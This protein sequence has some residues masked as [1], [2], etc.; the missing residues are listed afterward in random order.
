[1]KYDF[2]TL[3]MRDKI[4]SSKWA[5]MKRQNPNVKEGIVPFSTADMEFVCPPEFT[6]GLKDYI[7]GM[8]FGY[9]IAGASYFEAVIDWMRRRH[10]WKIEREWIVMTPGVVTALYHSVRA[11]TDPGDG[12]LLMT[13]AYYP[14]YSAIENSG[15]TLVDVPLLIENDQYAIDFDLLEQE[16]KKPE[17][18]LI[19]FCS[20]AN[21]GGRVWSREELIRFG[22]ICIDN[23]LVIVSDD[24]HFDLIL[25]GYEHTV[26]ANI[27]DEFKEHSV[28]CT[29]P[30]KTF[31]LAGMSSSNII[32]ANE[33]LRKK[34][35]HAMEGIGA[36][37]MLHQIGYQAVE[38]AYTRCEGWLDELIEVLEAN[39]KLLCDFVAEYLPEIRL[40]PLQG[41][42][43]QWMD[44][45]AYGFSNEE[46]EKL[47][48]EEAMIFCNQG[49][50]FG[51]AGSGYIRMNLACPSF[52][53]REALER[54]R[55]ALAPYRK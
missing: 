15:R 29:A 33:D 28:I 26:F 34:F 12:V 24:I 8:I 17:N 19:L 55:D 18:K 49:Y 43:L 25:P 2:E 23:G 36:H 45:N 39:R 1:M 54:M 6:E 53:L 37:N 22:R 4:N 7:D 10:N 13:P 50:V 3:V 9:T 46:L 27:S 38:L 20:P 16:A 30:S 21:P 51:K 42:Y 5:N 32:I 44:L 14:M 41:T 48:Y 47:M 35:L 52:V 40:F 11:Y 31:N